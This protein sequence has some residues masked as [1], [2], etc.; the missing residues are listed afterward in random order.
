MPGAVAGGLELIG[1]RPLRQRHARQRI[2]ILLADRKQL[3]AEPSLV[4]ARHDGGPR[5][6][7][8][9]GRHVAGG[10]KH[11]VRAR[12]SMWGVGISR[13]T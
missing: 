3:V 10:E 5:R 8:H 13:G 2:E 7:A 4:S 6:A 9:G 12:A 11:A 1:Q